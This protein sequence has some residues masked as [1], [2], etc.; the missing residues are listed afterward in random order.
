MNIYYD[1]FPRN[2]EIPF[3]MVK[4]LQSGYLSGVIGTFNERSIR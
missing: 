4:E 3:F 2:E 1:P